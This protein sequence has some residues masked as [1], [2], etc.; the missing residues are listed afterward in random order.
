V[1]PERQIFVPGGLPLLLELKA[2]SESECSIRWYLRNFELH[3]DGENIVCQKLDV[4]YEKM[5]IL[6]IISVIL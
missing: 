1:A 6:F 4:N 2:E 3:A 5:C